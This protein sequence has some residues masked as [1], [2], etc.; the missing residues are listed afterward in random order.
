MS[1]VTDRSGTFYFAPAADARDTLFRACSTIAGFLN[2]RFCICEHCRYHLLQEPVYC[3]HTFIPRS[4][5][6]PDSNRR[7]RL[8]RP[9]SW[10]S[11]RRE[12]VSFFECRA[13]DCARTSSR[14]RGWQRIVRPGACRMTR[15]VR[16]RGR[17][18]RSRGRLLQRRPA[19]PLWSA[20]LL[21]CGSPGRGRISRC[22]AAM[23]CRGRGRAGL[24][25]C[26]SVR[27]PEVSL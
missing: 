24:W 23:C 20:R 22:C 4:Y 16:I 7:W 2:D 25:C 3:S 12:R 14:G 10:A 6:R 17:P 9:L 1:F 8:E 5:S 18:V 27:R 26:M 19:I 21:R 13:P 11:R 15:L